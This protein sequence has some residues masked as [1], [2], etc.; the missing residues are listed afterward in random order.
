MDHITGMHR[1]I[2]QDPKAVENF[3]H[4]SELNFDLDTADWTKA[5][6]R[7]SKLDWETYKRVRDSGEWRAL[8]QRQGNLR[9]FWDEDGIETG[10]RPTSWSPSRIRRTTRT[11][12]AWCSRS[13]MPAGASS[14]AA[15]R[16]E[17]RR[18]QRSTPTSTWTGVDVLKASH[19][20]RN[21]G[22]YWPAV[23]EMAPWLTITSVGAA[24]HDATRKYRQ[25]SEHTVSTR[26]TGDIRIRIEDDG[27]LIYPGVLEDHWQSQI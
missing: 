2:E 16:P 3:W 11:F 27:Q 4:S 15:T 10:H 5:A 7:Y 21:S 6:G 14:S 12:S 13:A 26:F 19:H 24:A 17:P 25:Y 1:L 23:K 22:Y 8:D 18:G 9:N 20:G